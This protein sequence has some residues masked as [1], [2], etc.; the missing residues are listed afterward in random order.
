MLSSRLKYQG[1][2][3]LIPVL[4]TVVAVP[5]MIG[6]G[7]SPLGFG[8]I[9]NNNS[10]QNNIE[11]P[12]VQASSPDNASNYF[13]LQSWREFFNAVNTGRGQEYFDRLEQAADDVN[14]T[15]ITD[16][17]IT[18]I[19]GNTIRV[20]FYDPGVQNKPAP[21]LIYVYGAGGPMDNF[22]PGLK[23]LANSTGF[24]LATMDYRFAP[25]SDSL[26]DVL[27]VVR[28]IYQNSD[29]LGVD[30][31]RIALGGVSRGANLALS[32]AM[33]L[34]D[35][36]NTEE[37]NLVRVLYLLNGYYSPDLLK[38]K[39]ATL[40]GNGMDFITSNDINMLLNQYHQNRS[41]YSNPLAFPILSKNLTGLP[42][43]YIAA[44]GIDPLRDDSLELAIRLQEEGQ[45][46]YLVSWPGVGHSAGAFLFIPVVPE[47]QTYLDSMALYLKGVLTDD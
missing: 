26:N 10:T 9:A 19:D 44:S 47:L 14:M 4:L 38:S 28:W 42:P 11:I 23:R 6:L 22:E 31:D 3:A 35:S 7:N 21:L 34:K 46:H 37:Q 18:G 32:T 27:A 20:R 2:V 30:S 40:F 8:Q 33:L 45:E 41:D 12:S 1:K 29:D 17:N 36:G 24:M 15:A 13:V 16:Y 39:S 43:V 5:L 25:F